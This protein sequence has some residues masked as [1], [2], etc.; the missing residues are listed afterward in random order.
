[1][2][3][4]LLLS[5]D[6]P[7]SPSITLN[8]SSEKGGKTST[9]E[10]GWG[11]A[12]YPPDESAATVIK[13]S[14]DSSGSTLSR[15]LRDWNR[16][17]SNIFLCNLRGASQRLSQQDIQPF[18]RSFAGKDWV[19]S[20]NGEIDKG[21]QE[22]LDPLGEDPIFE[23]MGKTD[24][25]YVFCWLLERIYKHSIR[26][27]AD[28]DWNVLHA[29]LRLLNEMG[30]MNIAFTDGIDM[31]VYQDASGYNPFY[32]RRFCPPHG[33]I[34]L[35]FHSAKISIGDARDAYRTFISFVTTDTNGKEWERM[36][37]GQMLVVRRGSI[38]WNS[39]ETYIKDAQRR[40]V[41]SHMLSKISER[42]QSKDIAKGPTASDETE[43]SQ[44]T[45]IYDP[46][47]APPERRYRIYHKTAYHYDNAVE[48]SKHMI[49]LHP[50]Q[51]R[52]Q[53][54]NEYSLKISVNGQYESFE[55]VFGNRVTTA[56][57]EE[58]YNEM[59]IELEATVSVKEP[60]KKDFSVLHG[61]QR[62]PIVW[63][64]W[65]RQMMM[66]FLL[67]PELPETQLSELTDFAMSFVERN[68]YRV[69]DVLNDINTTIYK[70]FQ[71]VSGSTG[72]ETTPFEVYTNRQGVCQDFANLFICL[73]QLLSIPARYRMGYIHTGSKYENTLQSDASHAWVEVFIPWLGWRGYDPT[74]GCSVGL[75]HIRVACGRHYYDATPTSGTIYKGGGHETLS[76]EVRVETIDE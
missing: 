56:K 69:M 14:E 8:S 20:H 32:W 35:D 42:L 58:D 16:F 66:P 47:V 76:I 75:D 49:R 13:D 65:Q 2:S 44:G 74:N 3:N 73:A 72:L 60:P 28:L 29:W 38:V 12:W 51:D 5:F 37:P 41:V 62:I 68:E 61:R 22:L 34:P 52:Y 23:P 9:A 63:M 64:P 21:K 19:F 40:R 18:S 39:D 15:V 43:I 6:C 57:L 33:K 53:T 26:S 31:V 46:A 17:Y 27:L 4:L 48:L 71:Y 50:V 10:Q 1:M 55:D 25:E 24:S 36:Q 70:D 11:F 45:R 59:Q 54:V 67:P 30:T 7:A